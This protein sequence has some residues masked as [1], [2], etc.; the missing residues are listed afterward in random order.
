MQSRNSMRSMRT[1]FWKRPMN[2]QIVHRNLVTMLLKKVFQQEYEKNKGVGSQLKRQRSMSI[3]KQ[4]QPS[5]PPLPFSQNLLSLPH[6]PLLPYPH[7]PSP[8][9]RLFLSPQNYLSLF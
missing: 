1:A 8:C 5:P 7:K 9:Y 3:P 6:P 4:I 2:L